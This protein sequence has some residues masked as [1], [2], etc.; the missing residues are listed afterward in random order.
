MG[1]D[2]L[3][4]KINLQF[5]GCVHFQQ[6]QVQEKLQQ[7]K[8]TVEQ[9][10]V[11]A[12]ATKRCLRRRPSDFEVAMAKLLTLLSHCQCRHWRFCQS[13]WH[14]YKHVIKYLQIGSIV[15]LTSPT[16]PQ[17]REVSWFGCAFARDAARARVQSALNEE[18]HIVAASPASPAHVR[19]LHPLNCFFYPLGGCS[20]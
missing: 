2:V 4:Q 10:T 13:R 11:T 1:E 15:P 17:W 3:L 9:A 7:T 16:Q 20:S 14:L 18:H 12:A 6:F 8:G 19:W 5:Q